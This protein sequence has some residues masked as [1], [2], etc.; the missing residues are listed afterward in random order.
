ML[1]EDLD[2]GESSSSAAGRRGRTEQR[3]IVSAP[4]R[5]S[6]NSF[7]ASG[8]LFDLPTFIF[9]RFSV[10]PFLPPSPST[11]SLINC[12]PV[13]HPLLLPLLSQRDPLSLLFS[14]PL[15]ALKKQKPQS[16][17]RHDPPHLHSP[18]PPRQRSPGRRGPLASRRRPSPPHPRRAQDGH[19]SSGPL[20]TGQ[21]PLRL[22]SLTELHSPGRGTAFVRFRPIARRARSL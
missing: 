13:S 17:S 21:F 14:P 20:P 19:S 9:F 5:R 12:W 16:T 18:R 22:L 10:H 11:P 4:R 15:S 3:R 2:V 8:L 6:L 7:S 1:P